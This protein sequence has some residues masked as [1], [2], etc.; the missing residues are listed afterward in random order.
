M[1]LSLV[2]RL[3]ITFYPRRKLGYR[4][5]RVFVTMVRRAKRLR[6]KDMEPAL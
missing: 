3:V 5:A 6:A 1:Y 4:T 2:S